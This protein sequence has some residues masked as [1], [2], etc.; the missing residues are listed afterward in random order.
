MHQFTFATVEGRRVA[1]TTAPSEAVINTPLLNKRAV[2]SKQK[3]EDVGL[4]G[5]LPDGD[6]DLIAAYTPIEAV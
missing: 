1:R 3:R 4:I 6:V 2:F 5:L